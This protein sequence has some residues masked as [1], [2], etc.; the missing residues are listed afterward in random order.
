ML[1]GRRLITKGSNKSVD[2]ACRALLLKTI[3]KLV[4]NAL[5][6]LEQNR[7][8]ALE[9]AGPDAVRNWAVGEVSKAAGF[10]SVIK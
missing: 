5:Y 1:F 9:T 6:S 7:I 10:F 3:D 2:E 4:Y 8:K